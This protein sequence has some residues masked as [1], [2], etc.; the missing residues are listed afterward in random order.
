MNNLFDYVPDEACEKA[1]R[2]LTIRLE[3]L[4]ESTN[5]ADAN[6][7]SEL[8]DGKMLGILIATDRNGIDHKLYA[9]SGQLGNGGFHYE[10]FVDTVFDYLEPGGYFKQKEADISRQNREISRF[11]EEPLCVL[12]REYELSKAKADEEISEYKEKCRQSKHVRDAK[13]SIGNIQEPELAAMIRQSQYEKAELHRLKRKIAKKLKPLAEQLKAA[14][15]QLEAMREKRRTDSEELQ[16]WLFTNFKVLNAK[17]ET[18]NL[19]EI[20]AETPMRIPPSGAGECCAPKL[21]QAAYLRGWQPKSIAEYW[22]GRPKGG[23]VRV[24][25]MNYPA[26]RGKCLPVLNWMLQGLQ[27][28]PPLDS[29]RQH[30]NVYNPE[31]IYENKWF[32]VI[33]KPSGMLSVP[34]K[35]TDISLQHWLIERYGEDRNV[36]MAHRLDQDTSGAIIAAFGDTSYKTMQALFARREVQKTYIADLDGDYRS[37]GISPAGRIELPLSPDRLDRPRQCVDI[38]NG[39]PA[40]TEYEFISVDNG[41]SRV[42]FR[43]LTGRTHQLRVHAASEM[44]LNMPIVGDRLYGRKACGADGRLHLHAFRIEFTFPLD[45][46]LYVF[47]TPVPF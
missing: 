44:G 5:P 23:E 30:C 3:S 11:E 18:K 33:N 41:F 14:L 12:R 19:S 46:K 13:R 20:F 25:G 28:D 4:R 26:C 21:L 24:H 10:G 39:K 17:G 16:N 29:D 37:Q 32:C 1:F 6:F 8:E 9:F 27:V 35:G 15:S 31:I 22:Y 40:L 34:G 38:D 7:I 45:G 43:P 36:K 47:E 2:E 42:I